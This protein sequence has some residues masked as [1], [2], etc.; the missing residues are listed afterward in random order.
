MKDS[1]H[2]TMED[3][4]NSEFG[5]HNPYFSNGHLYSPKQ[6]LQNLTSPHPNKNKSHYTPNNCGVTEVDIKLAED[7][8]IY[9]ENL[10]K[11]RLDEQNKNC[12][13][14]YFQSPK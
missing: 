8:R 9:K 2:K 14:N 12:E 13:N 10:E 3:I 1:N 7:M 11:Q 6:I 4:L 5:P